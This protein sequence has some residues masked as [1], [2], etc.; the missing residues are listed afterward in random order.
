VKEVREDTSARVEI[1]RAV[2]IEFVGQR[3]DP[4]PEYLAYSADCRIDAA[5]RLV[6]SAHLVIENK[7]RVATT[8]YRE[9]PTLDLG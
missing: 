7:V 3:L 4:L 5:Y 9:V 8:A 6:S 2:Y 1:G